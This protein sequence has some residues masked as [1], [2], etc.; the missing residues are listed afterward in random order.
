MYMNLVYLLLWGALS[1]SAYPNHLQTQVTQYHRCLR[2][3]SGAACT[4]RWYEPIYDFCQDRPGECS[5][6]LRLADPGALSFRR[7]A[8]LDSCAFAGT[9]APDHF[10]KV[11]LQP[12]DERAEVRDP[13]L[14]P[15]GRMGRLTLSMRL[16]SATK[17]T[18]DNQSI[19]LAQLHATNGQSPS[20]ALRLKGDDSVVVTVRHNVATESAEENGTEVIVTAWKMPRD[21][22]VELDIFV[23]TGSDGMLDI[24]SRGIPLAAYRGPL[25]YLNLPNYF[26]FGVYDYTVTQKSDFEIHFKDFARTLV[27]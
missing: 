14:L 1:S 8:R 27:D 25:G 4:K 19:V 22:W 10:L 12:G 15:Y 13:Y 18:S 24:Y 5:A 21:Q 26:K 11:V 23:R 20:F 7:C 3:D 17:L 6:L 16:P 2:A 9:Q